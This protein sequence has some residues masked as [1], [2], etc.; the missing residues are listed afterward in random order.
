MTTFFNY[1]TPGKYTV[2]PVMEKYIGRRPELNAIE[3]Q[4]EKIIKMVN[5]G[6]FSIINSN[7]KDDLTVKDLN[8]SDENRKIESLFKKLYK[9]KDFELIWMYTPIPNAC[10]PCKSLQ[11]LDRNYK[12]DKDGVDYNKK[13]SVF[14]SVNTGLITHSKMSAGEVL[15]IILHEVGHNFYQAASQLLVSINPV[16]IGV[17]VSKG[18]SA[19]AATFS[20]LLGIAIGD[21][22][23]PGKWM[24]KFKNLYNQ[25][26][27][28]FHLRPIENTLNEFALV[29][30]VFTPKTI[31]TL[32]EKILTLPGKLASG[33]LNPNEVIFLYS[34]EKHADSFAVD[35]GYGM[36]LASALNKLDMRENSLPYKIPG[37]NWFLDF[38]SLVH[39]L[40]LQTLS[41]YPTIH[42]RQTTALK[43]LKEARRDPNI[44]P[45]LKK[46]LDQQIKAFDEYYE[47]Y[48]N[49]ENDE[50]KRR[51]FTWAYRSFI[52]KVFRGN[53]DIRELIYKL[54]E[55]YPLVKK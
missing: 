34:V 26:I 23:N 32:A 15:A 30:A 3:K 21:F 2:E 41:G 51:V 54:E 33:K 53:A 11:M 36:E 14:V 44:S 16:M 27:D 17:Q 7:F 20:Q 35:Y 10:T 9:L 42:N 13:L 24:L 31:R 52:N 1:N 49:I 12:V 25:M 4:L 43:R 48:M 19:S 8:G 22:L 38:D 5:D 6:H 18:A 37:F 40:T 28:A 45:K 29:V 47:N 55:K 39:D 46:E 50:N